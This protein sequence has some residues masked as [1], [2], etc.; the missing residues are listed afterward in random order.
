[1]HSMILVAIG[2]NL[3]APGGDSP[4]ATCR[5]A[6]SAL[7]QLR[8]LRLRGLSRWWR[9][10]PVPASDQPDYINGMALLIG[11]AEPVALLRALQ[12][13]EARFGRRRGARDAARM[14]DLDII[15][16]GSL[17]RDAP[18]PILPHPR[19]HLRAFVL[20]PLLDVMPDWMHP[21]LGV[22]AAA[23]LAGLPAQRAEPLDGRPGFLASGA[24]GA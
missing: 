8:G 7:D 22:G 3:P 6:A 15:G 18:D 14:L 5:R 2:A 16:I 13:L 24:P 19:A 1:M 17:V 23:L 4:L 21:R 9:T 10:A 12:D 11:H 20:G